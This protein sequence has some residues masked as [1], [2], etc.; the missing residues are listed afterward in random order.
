M[1]FAHPLFLWGLLAASI[2]LLIHLFD[3]RRPKPHPFG[4]IS[5]VLK[6]Q[7]RTASRLKLKRLIL[8][9][10][11]TLMFLALPLALS[12]PEL[13][14]EAA[15]GAAVRG[16]AATAI[17][18]D[19]SLSMRW[20]DGTS[21]FSRAQEEAREALSELLPEEPAT[22]LLCGQAEAPLPPAGFDRR[23]L[24]SMVDEAKAGYAAADL[25]SCLERAARALEDS[26]IAAKRLVVV[27]DFT[28]NSLRLEAPVPTVRGPKGEPVRPEVQLR[29]VAAH[30]EALPNRSIVE[31][32]AEPALQVGPRAF[33]FTFTVRNFSSEPVKNL[34][35]TLR[36]GGQA[37]AKGFVD[38]AAGGTAQKV[39][40]HRFEQGGVVQGEVGIEHDFLPE[41]DQRAFTLL[42]PKELRALVINGAPSTVRLKDEG[43]FV[44]AA[45]FAPGSPLRPTVRDAEAGLREDFAAYDVIFLL[46]VPAPSAEQALALESFVKQGGGLFLSMGDNVDP[47]LYSTRL[48][49]VLPR[50]LRL[51]KSAVDSTAP[52]AAARAARLVSVRTEH[53]VFSVF[54]GSA[55]E[56]LLSARFYRYM[57]LEAEQATSDET[58]KASQVL[59]TFED[60]APAFAAARRG[61]G[62]VL[63]YTSTVDRE[64][65]DLPIRTA[66]LPLLQRM[67]A[68]L[69]GGL[70]EQD[71]LKARVGE[72]LSLP[73]HG[74]PKP[75]MA[76][77]PGKEEL[78]ARAQP[79]GTAVV[80][81]LSSPGA[82]SVLDSKGQPLPSLAFS[83]GVDPAESDLS[84]IK[85]E[86][87][88]A[89]FGEE[90]VR[91]ASGPGQARQV[92]LWTWLVVLAACA[93]FFEGTLLRK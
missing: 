39:L 49:R 20:S 89:H 47:E 10:L 5:F 62:R 2:P 73:A 33:Q 26:P 1:S 84:R 35:A 31:L 90:A 24:R 65:A 70:E 56:G 6:S 71:E 36:V 22:V 37:V 77:G 91:S 64:W 74:E 81:P 53:P 66:F 85:P 41:D 11:R 4:A 18:L 45:L 61:K 75:A 29:D 69:C 93:F 78:P 27:S 19:T 9:V 92:P 16:P 43:F 76:K 44:E 51:P 17:V 87:L 13:R 60:G 12:R 59:A 57:L 63:L 28:A 15:A 52:D 82:W 55:Q 8:Y 7:K 72:T 32:K 3:R 46:N 30:A 23:K 34:E 40:T 80:G 21:H 42:V 86:L 67:G 14:K 50:P 83:V 25:S 68:Y 54:T 48:A 38:L 88:A 79:D 58:N